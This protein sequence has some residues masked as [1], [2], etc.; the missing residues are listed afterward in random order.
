MLARPFFADKVPPTRLDRGAGSRLSDWRRAVLRLTVP[1]LAVRPAGRLRAGLLLV[2]WLLAAN[3]LVAP[4]PAGSLP[5]ALQR[6]TSW[7][8][9]E[10]WAAGM[11]LEDY[12]AGPYELGG[13]FTLTNQL[14]RQA[15]LKDFRGRVVLVFF[16]Y[17]H[18]PDVCPL[19]LMEMGRLTK[20]LG[21]DAKRVQ[22]LFITV[23]P[24]RDTPRRLKSYLANFDPGIVGLTGPASDIL[25]IAAR[26]QARF[27]RSTAQ[28]RSGYLVDHTGFVYM[29]DGQGKVRYLFT[30][31]AG[32]DLFAQGVRRLLKG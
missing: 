9:A 31:D 18:C 1:R 27:T 2:A 22:I 32:V 5:A 8:G 16:G 17:I 28:S 14:G 4:L 25:A 30:Y 11:K 10:A 7:A 3:F 13:D 29:L 21:A 26:Y 23:D 6:A 20:R 12:E 19:T 15:S 24:V